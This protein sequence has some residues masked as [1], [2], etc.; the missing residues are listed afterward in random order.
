MSDIRPF[1]I[2]V[3]DEDIDDLRRRLAATR[4]P[5]AEA[6]D[7]LTQGIPLAYVQEV[8]QYWR[9]DYD[10]RRCEAGLN[11]HPNFIVE[12]DG[13]DIH[14]QHVRSPH[15]D[16]TPLVL[17]H[18]WPGSIVEFQKVIGPLTDPTAHGGT[19]GDAFHLVIPSLPGYGWSGKPT[20]AGWGVER[21][22]TAWHELMTTLGYDS[23][24]AQGGDWGSAV[25]TM[26]GAQDL[27]GCKAIHTNMPTV[28]PTADLLT[29]LTPQEQQAIEAA[30]FYQ[31]WDSGYSKQ[32]STRPQTL[33]YG[34][35]DSPAGQAAW[36]LEKFWRWTDCGDHI[37]NAL[38]RDELLDNVSVY[39]F[40]ATAAS[41]ARLYWESFGKFREGLVTMPTGCSI[42]PHEIIRSSRR[43]AESKYT[44][45]RYWNELDR[46]GHFAAFEQPDLFVSELRAAFAV[47]TGERL[48]ERAHDM[49]MLDRDGVAIYYEVRG[50]GPALLLTHGFA[51]SAEMFAKVV[52]PLVGVAHGDH[53]GPAWTRPQ[54][55]PHRSGVVL[56]DARRR[57]HRRPARRRRRRRRGRSAG[58]RSAAT[59]RSSSSSPTRHARWVSC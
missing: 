3:P 11:A 41:S 58:T 26:I 14:F 34:L 22:A 10:W 54:R 45:I 47:L 32:Q 19:A 16:A 59:C 1:T 44:D 30:K 37:E 7:D 23:F 8:C 18:G 17:T 36:I 5:E 53:V 12:I 2:A 21:I 27:G 43:W 38:T 4:W 20:A 13:L 50:T 39:W 57:R 52:G 29:D 56:A 49:S 31:D 6:V 35:V 55:L 42:Y 46:G 51:A 15:D 25:T 9:D 48:S 33:G 40:T 28:R 24:V